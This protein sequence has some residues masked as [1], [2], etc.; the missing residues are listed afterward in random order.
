M[1]VTCEVVIRNGMILIDIEVRGY[2]YCKPGLAYKYHLVLGEIVGGSRES[3][4]DVRKALVFEPGNYLTL[5]EC[6]EAELSLR[7]S[8]ATSRGRVAVSIL[9]CTEVHSYERG[10]QC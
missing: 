4:L 1:N 5:R 6:V 9:Y 10:R 3:Y 7:S 8:S 2:S